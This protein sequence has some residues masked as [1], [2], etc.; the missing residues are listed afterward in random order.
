MDP[1]NMT[2]ADVITTLEKLRKSDEAKLSAAVDKR[3]SFGHELREAQL[4]LKRLH[5]AG[6]GTSF[7]DRVV[8]ELREA[9]K[10][11]TAEIEA[12][13]LRIAAID[14]SIDAVKGK[15]PAS[16]MDNGDG[17]KYYYV[18]SANCADLSFPETCD[19]ECIRHLTKDAC[20]K[21]PYTSSILHSRNCPSYVPVLYAFNAAQAVSAQRD[22]TP[23]INPYVR[24]TNDD[25]REPRRLAVIAKLNKAL[26]FFLSYPHHSYESADHDLRDAIAYVVE[27]AVPSEGA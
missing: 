1:L 9:I 22:E 12:C 17:T 2:D 23:Q 27:S 25:P 8:M 5:S 19:R 4:M 21:G 18:R 3:A 26:S 16:S 7:F 11:G 24:T 14:K 15:P 10:Q 6:L 20:D 13:S